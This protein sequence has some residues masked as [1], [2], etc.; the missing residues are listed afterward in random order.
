[1]S[2]NK[3]GCGCPVLIIDLLSFSSLTNL[4][5]QAVKSFI[6]P[7]DSWGAKHSL[8]LDTCLAK[9]STDNSS[10][11][12]IVWSWIGFSRQQTSWTC[13][14]QSASLGILQ[15]HRHWEI[16]HRIHSL[17]LTAYTIKIAPWDGEW[18]TCFQI[19]ECHRFRR[20]SLSGSCQ[21]ILHLLKQHLQTD[22]NRCKES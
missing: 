2:L 6:G 9:R 8:I 10:S 1:M 11:L 22:C 21:P 19:R 14:H 20:S 7:R 4:R 18:L 12:G 13:Q 15:L 5:T 3:S 17:Y 16:R